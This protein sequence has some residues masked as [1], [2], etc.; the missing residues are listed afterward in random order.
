MTS[1]QNNMNNNSYEQLLIMK[2]AI[3]SNRQDSDDKMKKAHRITHSN[4]DIND[5]LD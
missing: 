3:E 1:G 5:G 2:A 4:D